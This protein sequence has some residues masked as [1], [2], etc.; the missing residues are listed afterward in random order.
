MREL[1]PNP[2]VSILFLTIKPPY[3]VGIY[4][5]DGDL[6]DSICFDGK[7][8]D[9]LPLVIK[10]LLSK[11]NP[12]MLVYAN[13]PGN[14]MAIKVTY[15]CLKTLCIAKNIPLKAVSSFEF[16]EYKPIELVN[17]R[18]FCF[19][20]DNITLEYLPNAV[21]GELRLPVS[22]NSIPLSDICEPIYIMPPA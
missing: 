10:E 3:L 12:T 1:L 20:N 2:S 7:T 5:M 16:N 14:Q 17:K 18:F 4:S 19:E 13:G 8:S 11:Y 15:V 9:T 22:I 21:D 6:I